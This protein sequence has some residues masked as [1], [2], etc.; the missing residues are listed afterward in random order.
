MSTQHHSHHEEEQDDFS[1]KKLFVP[2][3]TL[4]AIHIIVI[5][6]FIVFGN[7]LFNGFVWD[8]DFQIVHTAAV[9]NGKYFYYFTHTIGPYYRP[10]MLAS[11]TFIYQLFHLNAFFYHFIQLSFHLANAFL[12][13]SLLRYF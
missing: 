2:L 3:T 5:I 4:K 9:Q 11:Y 10:L 12:I 8:D 1:F 6:G 7:M 13:F